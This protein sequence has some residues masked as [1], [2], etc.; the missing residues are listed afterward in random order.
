MISINV[1]YVINVSGIEIKFLFELYVGQENFVQ[2]Q[3]LQLY[4]YTEWRMLLR[5]FSA[6]IFWDGT[7]LKK[8]T[9]FIIIR[10]IQNKLAIEEL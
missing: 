4:I 3:I 2:I 5:H 8:L 9:P 1:Y 6:Y 7:K 10:V